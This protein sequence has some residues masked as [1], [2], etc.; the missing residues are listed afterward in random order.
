MSLAVVYLIL[1]RFHETPAWFV[2]RTI[3]LDRH[4]AIVCQLV[5]HASGV[6]HSTRLKSVHLKAVEQAQIGKHGP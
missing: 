3:V 6:G 1:G 5:A 2:L 4:C